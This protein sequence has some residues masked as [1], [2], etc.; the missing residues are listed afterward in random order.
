MHQ[1]RQFTYVNILKQAIYGHATATPTQLIEMTVQKLCQ[2]SVCKSDRLLIQMTFDHKITQKK[3]DAFLKKW[4]IE[5]VGTHGAVILAYLMKKYP[6]LK[7]GEY[8]GPR[9]KGLLNYLRFQNLDLIGHFSKIGRRLNEKGIV[10]LL[11]KGGAIRSLR[12]DFPRVMGDIDILVR[13]VN[14]VNTAKKIIKEMGYTYT[15]E[16]HSFDVHPKDDLL[17]G[18]LDVHQYFGFLPG[19]NPV[20]NDEMF[21]RSETCRAFSVDVCMPCPED[22]F[23]I[24]LNNLAHNLR[25]SFSVQGIP[26]TLFDLTYLISLKKDFDWDIVTH[27]IILTQTEATS[28]LAIRFIDQLVPGIFP[29]TLLGN[30]KLSQKLNTFVEHEKF[31]T[32]YVHQVKY[33][34]KKLKLFKSMRHFVTFKKYLKCK[35]QHFFTK[36][37]LKHPF[38]IHLFLKCAG[39]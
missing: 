38:L 16:D 19:P 7:F 12:P 21:G 27:N 9:L 5:T 32:L 30:K 31:Y 25:N 29:D 10:P 36:R 33:A 17:K 28:Y 26:Q 20:L 2:E 8:T 6:D 13:S 4:D 18:I 37:I 39:R 22:L 14:Q 15:S 1:E 11:I 23:F 24:C 34:C 3:L 35:G